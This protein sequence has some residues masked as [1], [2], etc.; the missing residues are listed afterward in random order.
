MRYLLH[1]LL[2]AALAFMQVGC[3]STPHTVIDHQV[4]QETITSFLVAQDR[5]TMVVV[6]EQHHF[7]MTLKEPLRS[8]MQWP[9]LHKLSPSFSDFYVDRDQSTKGSYTLKAPLSTLTADERHFLEQRGFRL[10]RSQTTLSFSAEIQGTRYLAGNVRLPQ[11]A[12]FKQPYTL[13]I[14]SVELS[15]RYGASEII[16]N[17]PLAVALDGAVFLVVGTVVLLPAMLLFPESFH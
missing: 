15:Q 14:H 16:T 10:S 17:S 13:T 2:I 6:S 3:S 7:I 8:V 12:S 1:Y 11:A 9:S 4:K 5:S